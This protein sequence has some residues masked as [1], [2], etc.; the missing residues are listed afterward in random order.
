MVFGPR[1]GGILAGI[2]RE[3]ARQRPG[4]QHALALEPK[5]PVQPTRVM[6]L[7]DKPRALAQRV[8]SAPWLGRLPE[9]TLA[10]IR[11]QRLAIH[12]GR[13]THLRAAAGAASARAR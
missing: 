2:L 6:L 5:V 12:R 8:G 1:G 3:P 9:I 4:H 10:P 11:S 7:H 13:P